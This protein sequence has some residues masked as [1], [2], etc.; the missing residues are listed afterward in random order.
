MWFPLPRIFRPP[1]QI[2]GG[3]DDPYMLRWCLLPENNL[4]N[5]FLHC[6]LRDDGD[7]A[8]HDHP[9]GSVSIILKGAYREMLPDFSQAPTPYQ[10]VTDVPLR[11]RVRRAG[12]ACFRRAVT[13]HRLEIVKGPV[14]TLFITGPCVREWGFHHPEGWCPFLLKSQSTRS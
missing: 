10:R 9:W 5:V 3:R 7:T 14:W 11:S 12:N 4:F 2:I 8:L 6:I 1:D 13:A